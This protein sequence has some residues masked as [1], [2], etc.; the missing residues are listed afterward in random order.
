M[1]KIKIVPTKRTPEFI[2]DPEGLIKIKGRSIDMH[3]KDICQPIENWI[4][5]YV[6]DPADVTHVEFHFEYLKTNNLKFYHSLLEKIIKVLLCRKKYFITWIYDEGDI[7]IYEKGETISLSTG[8][9][10]NYLMVSDLV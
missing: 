6:A 1:H 3:L 4:D 8:V 7:D 5:K 9:E 2:L 10:I